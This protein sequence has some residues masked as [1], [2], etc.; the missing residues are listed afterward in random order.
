MVSYLRKCRRLYNCYGSLPVK[1]GPSKYAGTRTKA[2]GD[3][4]SD[5]AEVSHDELLEESTELH[6]NKR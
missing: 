1:R 5:L 3:S 4:D 6:A 2:F